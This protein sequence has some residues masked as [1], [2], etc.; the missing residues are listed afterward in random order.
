MPQHVDEHDQH[1]RV[2]RV[3]VHAAQDAAEVPLAVGQRLHRGVRPGHAGIEEGVQVQPAA[4]DQ[5]E[6]E[7]ADRAELVE[8]VDAVAERAVEQRLDAH[9]APAQQALD[10]LDHDP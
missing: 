3:A 2:R 6:Q 8:R 5:P 10:G 4:G 7:E 9:E 1:Q